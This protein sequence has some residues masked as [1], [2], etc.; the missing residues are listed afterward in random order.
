[1]ANEF[2]HKTVGSE[3]TQTEFEAVGGH[4]L[5]SQATGDIIYASSATQLTRLP[6]G[7]ANDVLTMGGSNIPAWDSTWTPAGHLIPSADDSYDLGSASAAWQDLFLEGDI[8]LTDAGTISTTAGA[9]SITPASGSAIVLDT[10]TT[11]DGGVLTFTP[12]TDDT[13]VMTAATNGAF[14]LVTTDNA[15]AAAN[16]QITADGTVDIDSAGVVTLDSGAAI[17]IEPASGS[18]I[19]LDGTISIDAGVVTGATSI[20]STAF[21]GNVTG[22]V[23]G[24]AATVTG[25]TQAAITSTANLVRVG[26][27]GTGVWEGTDV[28]VAHGGTGVSTLL[29][30]AVLT[31][32]GTSAIQAESTL[33]FSSNKLI[34]TA[35]AHDAAG[36]ALTMSAG[37][38][39]AGTTNNIAGGALTFQGGQGKGSGAGGDIIFQTANAG[40]SGSS[41]NALATALTL[42]DDLSAAF[43]GAVTVAG[44]LTVNGTTTTVDTETLA[45]EDPLIALA[46]GNNSA[47]AVD[48]GIYG[49]Y[50]TSG[51][52]D[53]YAGLF[54]D[55][56]DSGKWKLFKDNQAAPTTTVNT[57]GTGY[58]VGTLVATLE[59]NVTGNVTGNA[60]GTAATVTGSTQ[61]NITTV[62]NVVEVGALDAGSISSNFG[63]INIGASTFDTTGAVS[64]G[65]LSPAGDVAIAD[66]KVIK[67][68]GTRPAD[69]EPATG[70]ASGNNTGYGIVVLFDAGA[71]VA[72]GDAV[73]IGADG[74]VIKTV[75]DATGTLSGPCIGVATTAAGSADDDVYVMT[76][77]VF[78]HD[79]WNFGTKGQA[80]YIEEAD[81]GDLSITAPNDDGDY[82]Q[83]V[84]VAI[85]DD[86]LLVMPSIDVIEHT[87]A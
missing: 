66:G 24:T 13:V 71:A 84:G 23:S 54:R 74:R 64:T 21:V 11:L 70:G 49:L 61:A 65:N 30:N 51:S 57:S 58:A 48:I 67:L 83:R 42:S 53:L 20:T 82:A 14:S 60:S 15:A 28:G 22:N 68:G 37:A 8:T 33:L 76:H 27:I 34:P 86:V 78:R 1:M 44:N 73:S 25:G 4:V 38:T 26:T 56:N 85:T 2:K 29:T 31:G 19:L 40:G 17:N 69:D 43:A 16:I 55:A 59:G 63:N 9:L 35:S 81:P 6:R 79:D 72:I 50:D 7:S 87:G 41:L 77:G 52:Q 45:V 39:T 47:D 12:S 46:T 18:A 62:A 5:D 32:N 80:V 10:S 3:L 36:T 75:A